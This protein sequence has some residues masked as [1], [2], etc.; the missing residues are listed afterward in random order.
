M[1]AAVSKTTAMCV[2]FCLNNTST[3]VFVNP[4]IAEVS[5]PLELMGLNFAFALSAKYPR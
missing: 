2:G 5:R 3:R 1:G 4:K